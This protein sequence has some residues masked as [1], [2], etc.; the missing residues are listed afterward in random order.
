MQAVLTRIRERV[1]SDFRDFQF[2][3]NGALRWTGVAVATLFFAALTTLYFLDWNQMRGPIS[4]YASAKLGREVRINGDLRVDLFRSQPHISVGN[5]HIGNPAWVGR[6]AS[7]DVK[8]IEVEF[9]LWPALFGSLIIPLLEIDQPD[10]LVVRGANGRTNWDRPSSTNAPGWHIPPI[11]RLVVNRGHLE[12]DDAIRKLRFRGE[13]SSVERAGGDPSGAAKDSGAV[14][15]LSGTGSLNSEKFSADIH[16][17]PLVNIDPD[18]PY[19][20]TADI[21]A[22]TTHA[23]IDGAIAHPFHLD[24]FTAHVLFTGDSLATLYYLTGLALPRTPPYHIVADLKRDGYFFNLTSLSG[25]VGSS[26]LHGNLTVDVSGPIPHFVGHLFSKAISFDDIGALLRG[27]KPASESRTFLLP[28]VTL[29]TER[30]RELSGEIDYEA[31]MIRSRDLPMRGLA[32]H[33]RVRDAVMVLKPLVFAFTQGKL[34]GSVS[35]DAHQDVPTTAVDARITDVHLEH[36]IK[37]SDKPVQGTLEARAQLRGTGTSVHKAAAAASGTLTLVV[38]SGQMRH[39][40]AE[41]L[42]INVISAL[43][44]NLTGDTSNTNVRCAVA[45][46]D[47]Q[48]G[49]FTAQQFV[50]DT[51]PVRVDG[52]GTINLV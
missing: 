51:D 32:T 14:F 22:G 24:N 16:G 13:V 35:I 3:W 23:V 48:H 34:S 38:P 18:R 27:G 19:D 45:H 33:I 21:H 6:P 10:I 12:I 17:G 49:T 11:Q 37:G 40:L 39:S 42:G 4:R 28:D 52:R 29:H 9:R 5:L 15:Q 2:T 25:L 36:F 7:A 44:L 20:F 26:D 8:Q 30:L 1:V 46:F 43:G 47:V 41:W 31:D 50:F